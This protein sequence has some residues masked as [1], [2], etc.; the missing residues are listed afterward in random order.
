V[1]VGEQAARLTAQAKVK[2]TAHIALVMR[3]T[4]SDVMRFN[5]ADD[6]V[7]APIPPLT[8][9][10]NACRITLSAN[11][12]RHRLLRQPGHVGV[13]CFLSD[14]GSQHYYLA[15]RNTLTAG[16]VTPILGTVDAR[17]FM[18]DGGTATST[19]AHSVAAD[20]FSHH[21]FVPIGYLSPPTS[22]SDP[23]VSGSCPYPSIRLQDC[24]P[25]HL[26]GILGT[27]GLPQL[28]LEP[29]EQPCRAPSARPPIAAS[30]SQTL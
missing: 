25:Q 11:C 24:R 6:V 7:A 21:V 4:L 13:E 19:T 3:K 8:Y 16:V 18:F 12:K 17:T 28:V 5:Q 27:V 23:R 22:T 15:A 10:C 30:N 14:F 20:K 26:A 2:I 29:A 9:A 1:V